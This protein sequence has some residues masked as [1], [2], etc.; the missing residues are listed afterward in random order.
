M[1]QY[2]FIKYI[3]GHNMGTFEFPTTEIP[4]S[5]CILNF[6]IYYQIALQRNWIYLR[7]HQ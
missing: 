2:R 6:E 1:L 7:V 4:A 5:I 3:L